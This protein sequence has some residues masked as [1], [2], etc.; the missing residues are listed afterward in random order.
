V[1]GVRKQ[2]WMGRNQIDRECLESDV[3]F[4]MA[5][6]RELPGTSPSSE[7][8]PREMGRNQDDEKVCA[9]IRGCSNECSKK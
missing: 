1:L 3:I 6:G 8:I 7:C 2:N 4:Q 9:V 5:G